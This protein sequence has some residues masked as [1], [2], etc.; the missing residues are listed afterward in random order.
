LLNCSIMGGRKHCPPFYTSND[1]EIVM[2]III[3]ALI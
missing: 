2:K 1:F 3:I